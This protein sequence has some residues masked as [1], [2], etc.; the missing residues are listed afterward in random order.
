MYYY[1]LAYKITGLIDRP[2][3]GSLGLQYDTTFRLRD[4]YVSVL[5]VAYVI[6]F[7]QE[8]V[9]PFVLMM[10]ERKTSKFTTHSSEK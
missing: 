7:D 9:Q 1:P 10:H 3:L 6:E 5:I 4:N 8:P 2:D